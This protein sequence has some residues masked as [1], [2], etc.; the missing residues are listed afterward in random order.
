MEDVRRSDDGELCGFV[1]HRDGAWCALVVFGAELGRHRTRVEA[2]AQ[3]E[4]EGLS[5]LAEPWTLRRGDDSEEI[6]CIQ[7]ANP[8]SVTVAIGYNS[9]PGVPRVTLNTSGIVAS[10]WTMHRRQSRA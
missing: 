7:E 1:D 3:V 8:E 2:V 5:S 10:E 6:V 4:A 9:M